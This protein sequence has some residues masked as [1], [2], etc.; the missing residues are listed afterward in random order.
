MANEVVQRLIVFTLGT[1][2]LVSMCAMLVTAH[3]LARAAPTK[4]AALSD[5]PDAGALIHVQEGVRS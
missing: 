5:A 2:I 1:A 4:S 3:T